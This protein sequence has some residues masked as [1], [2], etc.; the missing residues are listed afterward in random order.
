MSPCLTRPLRRDR[1]RTARLGFGSENKTHYAHAQ[2]HHG[3]DGPLRLAPLAPN[4]YRL[5]LSLSLSTLLMCPLVRTPNSCCINKA[6]QHLSFDPSLQDSAWHRA[7]ARPKPYQTAERDKCS[8]KTERGE[9][10]C[11]AAVLDVL[12]TIGVS[13]DPTARTVATKSKTPVKRALSPGLENLAHKNLFIPEKQAKSPTSCADYL[14]RNPTANRVRMLAEIA[15]CLQYLHTQKIIHGSIRPESLFVDDEGSPLLSYSP[16]NGTSVKGYPDPY[17][18]PEVQQTSGRSRV[19]VQSDIYSFGSIVHWMCTGSHPYHTEVASLP[20]SLRDLPTAVPSARPLR[21][22]ALNLTAPPTDVQ[23]HLHSKAILAELTD[24]TLKNLVAQ[25]RSSSP[26]SR[27]AMLSIVLQLQQILVRHVLPT[28]PL[29][30]TS[31]PLSLSLSAYLPQSRLP[32]IA[33]AEASNKESRP[34]TSATGVSRALVLSP[35]PSTSSSLPSGARTREAHAP[36]QPLQNSGYSY[37]EQYRPR[38]P[39]VPQSTPYLNPTV[40]TYER[41][42]HQSWSHAHHHHHNQQQNTRRETEKRHE[43][44]AN[45]VSLPPTPR[46]DQQLPPLHRDSLPKL[47]FHPPESPISPHSQ[48][49]D[50]PYATNH[51]ATAGLQPPANG[52]WPPQGGANI[53]RNRTL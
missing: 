11:D 13:L 8:R 5:P 34:S 33:Q 1:I 9:I 40:S 51:P 3:Y 4:H 41:G 25:C 18:A 52:T 20:P 31:A 38:Q 35:R 15:A 43:Y 27:P 45:L 19:T 29:P 24:Y 22:L 2:K 32:S 16:D 26:A 14:K 21:S 12:D 49:W 47:A 37:Q 23:P 7:Q 17:R 39:S 30:P 50:P 10:V 44:T 42:G 53:H 48:R 46:Y 6:I 28:L 36:S